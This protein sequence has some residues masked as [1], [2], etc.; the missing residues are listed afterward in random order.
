MSDYKHHD[1]HYCVHWE[2]VDFGDYEDEDC[3]AE[4]CHYEE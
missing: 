4:T 2:L 3:T 1:C